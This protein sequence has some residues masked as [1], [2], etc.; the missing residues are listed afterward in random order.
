MTLRTRMPEGK[1]KFFRK[2]KAGKKH[3]KKL[4]RANRKR[5]GRHSG[6]K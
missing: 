4:R 2:N 1:A 6:S 3:E 5:R